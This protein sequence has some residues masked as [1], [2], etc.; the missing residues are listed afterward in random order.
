[1]TRLLEHAW[2]EMQK[3]PDADQDAIASLIL[4]ESVD[5]RA[6][7]EAFAASQV[8][9]ARLAA[10]VREDIAAG[11]IRPLGPRREVPAQCRSLIEW[12][13]HPE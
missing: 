11:R 12:P 7:D 8:Q 10:K 13:I 9:L 1:M 2:E 6:C 5:E 3:P 4:R